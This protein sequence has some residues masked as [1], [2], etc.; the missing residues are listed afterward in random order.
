M[1]GILLW[2]S[3]GSNMYWFRGGRIPIGGLFLLWLLI[4][5]LTGVLMA[6]ILLTEGSGCRGANRSSILMGLCV[7]SYVFM[8]SWYAVYFCTRLLLFSAVLL[9]LSLICHGIIFVVMRTGFILA[10]F[11]I[12][13]GV[14]CQIFS[15]VFCYFVNLLI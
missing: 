14:I 7:V 4:Y 11:V 5:G 15:L 9:I 13:L 10:K 12:L 3:G 6:C 8:L 1:G 2:V